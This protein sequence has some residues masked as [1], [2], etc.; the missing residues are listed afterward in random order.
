MHEQR[1]PRQFCRRKSPSGLVME[2]PE[3][4]QATHETRVTPGKQLFGTP[5]LQFRFNV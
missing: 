1:R 5:C 3:K 4:D 2:G